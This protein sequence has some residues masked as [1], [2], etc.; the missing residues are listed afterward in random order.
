MGGLDLPYFMGKPLQFY[1][2]AQL[3]LHIG[4]AI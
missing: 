2:P 1:C 4:L 3:D